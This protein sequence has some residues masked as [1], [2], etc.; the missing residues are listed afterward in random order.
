MNS[1]I[2]MDNANLYQD[3][4]KVLFRGVNLGNWMLIEHF[5]I[6][7]PSVEY[8]IRAEFRNI[9][10]EEAYHV[11]FDT[12][13]ENYI[14]EDDFI[15]LKSL[16]VNLARL[17]F[18]Y[19]YFEADFHPG[20]YLESGFQY[21]DKIVELGKKYQIYIILDLHS[22]PGAQA[23]DWNAESAYGE[24][25]LWDHKDFIQRTANIWR[26]IASRYRDE[27]IVMGYEILNEPVTHNEERLH[28]FNMEVIRAIREVDANHIII[29]DCNKHATDINSLKNEV[30][31]DPLVMPTVHHY[32][33][34][35][36]PFNQIP[37]F[38]GTFEGAYYDAN[39]LIDTCRGKF[40]R[41]RIKRP[42]LLSEF[43]IKYD[44]EFAGA[45]TA[46]MDVLLD[47]CNSETI[48]WT[49]WSYKDLGRMGLI[50]PKDDTPWQQFVTRDDIGGMLNIFKQEISKFSNTLAQKYQFRR[51]NSFEREVL[52]DL[53]L[54]MLPYVLKK[55]QDYSTNDLIEMAKSFHFRNCRVNRPEMLE[56]LR[57]RM[58]ALK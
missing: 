24:Y 5:M 11:F 2:Q 32:H 40:D 26:F 49:I 45:Q 9:L 44:H 22:A 30:F 29:V 16:G 54:E 23:S 50:K 58:A 21:I 38:P 48:H 52:R 3:G 27:G 18:S 34:Y 12:Y 51:Q 37:S 31:E 10:G 4:K 15:F 41:Q 1:L 6:G 19:R 14:T 47:Y 46:M 56:V 42:F 28:F 25:L 36:Y 35:N 8:K 7:L 20:E 13:M 43:G 55:L 17:P 39:Q 33:T 53:H 57:Q